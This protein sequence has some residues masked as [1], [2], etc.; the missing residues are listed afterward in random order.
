MTVFWPFSF[1]T[2]TASSKSTVSDI[3]VPTT[4]IK[5]W[6]PREPW[7]KASSKSVHITDVKEITHNRQISCTF[8]QYWQGMIVSWE[9]GG[10]HCPANH[11]RC[12]VKFPL[13]LHVQGCCQER[14]DRFEEK[15]TGLKVHWFRSALCQ[16]YRP[17]LIVF[18]IHWYPRSGT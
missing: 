18:L 5:S 2:K 4:Q 15:T 11:E 10:I 13:L 8:D 17:A 14:T 12:F 3:E 6:L 16:G 9:E 1:W 7:M